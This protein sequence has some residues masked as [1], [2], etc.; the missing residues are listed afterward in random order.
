MS[1]SGRRKREL[2]SARRRHTPDQV[3]TKLTETDA[4]IAAGGTVAESA[5]RIGATGNTF[6]PWRSDCGG[7]MID[8][9]GRLKRLESEN[10]RPKRAAS[11]LTPDN[12]I[13]REASGG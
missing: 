3:N 7:P 9:A 8:Q 12:R 2:S 13:L 4:A 6:Y 11:K 5:H 10:S 1:V